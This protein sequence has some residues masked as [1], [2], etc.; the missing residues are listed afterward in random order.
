VNVPESSLD[1]FG[2]STLADALI[3]FSDPTRCILYVASR[4]WPNG[5][6][7]CPTCLSTK[8]RFLTTR[9]LWECTTPHP[10]AQFS[11]RS[12]TLFEDSHISL[13]DW[14]VAIWLTA[15]AKAPLSSYQIAAS[16]GITQKSAW[17]MLRRIGATLQIMGS[18]V[19]GIRQE[20][21]GSALRP[22]HKTNSQG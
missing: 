14:L 8:V 21:Y 20:L 15:N 10:K 19:P 7:R 13:R 16:L 1:S 5:V 11:V 2:V 4:R 6:V 12:G 17:F 18:S 22:R 9:A 3:Y